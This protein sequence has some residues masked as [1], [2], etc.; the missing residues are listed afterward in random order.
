MPAG[1]DST[2][3]GE[4]GMWR[5]CAQGCVWVHGLAMCFE[6]G[7]P[8]FFQKVVDSCKM[9]N[10]A[11][12]A[13]RR[14][15]IPFDVQGLFGGSKKIVQRFTLDTTPRAHVKVKAWLHRQHVEENILCRFLPLSV[16]SCAEHRFPDFTLSW[17][18]KREIEQKKI[19]GSEFFEC[20][21]VF[22]SC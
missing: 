18:R 4:E 12:N 6:F 21:R 3:P 15:R 9:L 22:Q 17:W 7:L 16:L 2:E 11:C 10:D 5:A 1:F 8:F 19:N 13:R 20:T 14:D